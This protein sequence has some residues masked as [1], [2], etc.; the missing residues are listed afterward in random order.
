ML[1]G[2][3]FNNTGKLLGYLVLWEDSGNCRHGSLTSGA[4]NME[5]IIL[6]VLKVI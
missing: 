1:G 2:F 4:G 5:K 6:V 3:C